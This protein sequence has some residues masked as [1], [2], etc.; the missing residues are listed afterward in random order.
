MTTLEN[1][2]FS[3]EVQKLRSALKRYEDKNYGGQTVEQDGEFLR[4]DDKA[5]SRRN[6][7]LQNEELDKYTEE[8]IEQLRFYQAEMGNIRL[9]IENVTKENERLHEQLKES[10]EKQLESIPS[11]FATDAFTEQEQIKNLQE[12]LQLANQTNQQFLLT[13]NKQQLEREQLGKQVRQAKQESQIATVK[14]EETTKRIESLQEQLQRKEHD[15][16]AANTKEEASENRVQQLQPA[17]TQLESRLKVAV[18]DV[19]KLKEERIALEKLIGELQAKCAKFEEEKYVAVSRV[20][21]SMQILEEAN[22]QKDQ[23]LVREKQ[24]EEE[25]EN[26][27]KGMNNI[28]E[29]AA[30]R[31]RKEVENTRKLFN[32][33]I[34][35]LTEE[36]SASHLECGEKQSQLERALREKRA[37][38]EEL[39]KAYRDGQVNEKDYRK[40]EELHQRF[41]TA[42]SMKDDLKIRLHAAQ[43]KIKQMELNFTED[44]SRC[45][46]TIEKLSKTLES[47][48][49]S[50]NSVSEERLKLVQENEQLRKEVEEWQKTATEVQQ[51]VKFQIS[52]LQHE[53]SVKKQGF[54][55]QL[56]EMED[57]KRNSINELRMLLFAQQKV[58]NQWKEE[59][60]QITDSTEARL[61]NLRT[62]LER[63]KRHSEELLSRLQKAQEK[64]TGLECVILDYQEKTNRLQKRLNQAEDLAL[65][66]SKQLSLVAS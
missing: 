36:L 22:L 57:S 30:A 6:L 59:A 37:A 3:K 66:A 13:V 5:T 44:L 1:E 26:M 2:F 61:G 39:A 12:Q 24:K 52:T 35:R 7:S 40:Q 53:F 11:G 28:I 45:H 56:Q 41:L 58:T 34:A 42:E 63:Q 60:R 49:K 51:N 38:E 33:Q 20:R 27:K 48:R 43:N 32:V 31:T 9:K 50:S 10:L 62:K 8:L 16:F 65:T 46:E 15:E 18:Q 25:I 55:V 17:F 21:D 64:K 54:K 29:E 23:A 4:E 19:E 47:E 14:L